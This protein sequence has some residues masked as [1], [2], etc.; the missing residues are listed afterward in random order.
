MKI[1]LYI[2]LKLE[3]FMEI[4]FILKKAFKLLKFLI[5]LKNK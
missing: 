4:I 2:I 1:S 3:I 5:L